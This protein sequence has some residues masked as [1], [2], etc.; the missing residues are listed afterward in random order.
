M[1]I[2]DHVPL[3]LRKSDINFEIILVSDFLIVTQCG[4]L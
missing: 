2:Y 3:L 4:L 1:Y